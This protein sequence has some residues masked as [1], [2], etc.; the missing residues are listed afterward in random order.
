VGLGVSRVHGT[1]TRPGAPS[2]EIDWQ[3]DASTT[4]SDPRRPARPL[5][6]SNVRPGPYT[7]REFADGRARRGMPNPGITVEPGK[8]IDLGKLRGPRCAAAAVVEIG[9]SNEPVRSF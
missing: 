7:L 1:G 2:R 8:S 4:S 6:L 3:G 5:T 9:I